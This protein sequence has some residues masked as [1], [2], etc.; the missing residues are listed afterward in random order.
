MR[1]LF[2]NTREDARSNPGGDTVQM[3][4]TQAA[5]ENLGVEVVVRGPNELGDLPNCDLAHL[6]NI[7]MPESAWWVFQKLRQ[8]GLPLVLSSI[9]WDMLEFWFHCAIE[10]RARWRMLAGR[11]GRRR[12]RALYLSWQR[13]KQPLSKPWRLQRRLLLGASRVLPNSHSEAQRLRW[14]FGLSAAFQQRVDVIPNGIDVELYRHPPAPSQRFLDL[15]GVRDFILEVGVVNPVKN[16]LGLI[17]ALFDLPRPLV[18]LGQAHPAYPEYYAACQQRAAERGNVIFIN[19]LPHHELPGVYALAAVHVLPSWRETPGLVSLEA[20]ASGCRVV[21]TEIGSARDYF[22]EQAWYCRPDD[23][24]SI[25]RA[26]E[27]ALQAPP[28]PALR[29]RILQE[30]TWQRAGEATLSAYEHALH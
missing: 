8:A 2:V 30:F 11:F 17:E 28:S 19:R 16:Q 13:L 24:A 12:I 3:E 4:K 14:A 15:Y 21:S 10:E 29:Q 20:A 26:V 22:G 6:F 1:V 27:A 9:Y 25:R 23:P 5:L 18:I 7:Q